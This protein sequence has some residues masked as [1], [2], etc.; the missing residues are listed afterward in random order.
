M[1]VFTFPYRFTYILSFDFNQQSENCVH[2]EL[3]QYWANVYRCWSSIETIPGKYM[4]VPYDTLTAL[5]HHA[6]W[7]IPRR[8]TREEW[9]SIVH[10][11]L[12][13]ASRWLLRKHKTFVWHLYN[14]GP[15]SKTL[16][17]HRINV[18]PM[19]CVYWVITCH[20][21]DCSR[22]ITRS[23]HKQMQSGSCNISRGAPGK[24]RFTTA[25]LIQVLV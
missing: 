16:D 9:A 12:C 4:C 17:L 23:S 21:H 1:S 22:L 3:P 25:I 18:T 13:C 7:S 8:Q 15:T 5:S 19:F 6:G 20:N 11:D 2:P 10:R 14:V 24:R